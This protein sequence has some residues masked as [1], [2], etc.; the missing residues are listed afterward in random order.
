VEVERL[1]AALEPLQSKLHAAT[2]ATAML[3]KERNRLMEITNR[4]CSRLHRLLASTSFSRDERPLKY[5][6]PGGGSG[7]GDDGASRAQEC[8]A[9]E[10]R[11]H[12]VWVSPSRQ[13]TGK[14]ETDAS[15]ACGRAA[16]RAEEQTRPRN[17]KE[18]GQ[19]EMALRVTGA[20]ACFWPPP[21]R[22]LSE[23]RRGRRSV[24]AGRR[25][26]HAKV[27]SQEL[28]Q[29]SPWT[30]PLSSTGCVNSNG[31]VFR[32]KRANGS[33]LRYYSEVAGPD[34]P[35]EGKQNAGVPHFSRKEE[36][37]VDTRKETGQVQKRSGICT[38]GP[39]TNAPLLWIVQRQQMD[40]NKVPHGKH[41]G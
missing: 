4:Q 16:A 28:R 3:Q 7:G 29:K 6:Q 2:A 10:R 9:E 22:A 25:T 33:V 41:R 35:Q 18:K 40:E 31:G 14:E 24:S 19:G 30:P 27:A 15:N 32:E 39:V 5:E 12:E 23:R 36:S 11:E 21:R 13:R 26:V 1:E 34:G 20:S 38:L 37:V 8:D 17:G